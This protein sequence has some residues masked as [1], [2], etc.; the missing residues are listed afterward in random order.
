MLQTIPQAKV[1]AVALNA[2]GVKY[3]VPEPVVLVVAMVDTTAPEETSNSCGD[4]T[5]RDPEPPSY[6][7][8]VAFPRVRVVL[9]M[10]PKNPIASYIPPTGRV[11]E[12]AWLPV[13]VTLFMA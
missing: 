3:A 2:I 12:L 8:T 9:V 13:A 11:V 1:V 10:C 7:D 5:M 6:H 4:A